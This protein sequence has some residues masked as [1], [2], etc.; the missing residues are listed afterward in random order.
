M[1][2]VYVHLLLAI[3]L[4]SPGLSRE[5]HASSHSS[6][7]E[8]AYFIMGCMVHVFYQNKEDLDHLSGYLNFL[9]FRNNVYFSDA[10]AQRLLKDFGKIRDINKKC[11]WAH[12]NATKDLETV[13]EWVKKK[14]TIFSL[15][16]IKYLN[17]LL[18]K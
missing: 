2:L 6:G 13:P 18:N 16:A 9:T 3:L 10:K 7:D 8:F 5:A 15:G 11:N 4:T 12:S 1:K 14:D 17:A